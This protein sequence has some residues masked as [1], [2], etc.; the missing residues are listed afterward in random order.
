MSAKV[1]GGL[2]AIL[3]VSTN[4]SSP[5]YT[6]IAQVVEIGG[7]DWGVG[8]ADT[9]NLATPITGT[10]LRPTIAKPGTIT[11][12]LQYDPNDST[13]Q[14]LTG[15]MAA[16]AMAVWKITLTDVTPMHFSAQG[17]LT[18]F[19]LTGLAVESNVEADIE[20]A[21]SGPITIS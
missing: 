5:S 8:T 3:A 15:L 1:S 6:T 17:V 20:I 21:L 4:V 14:I 12:K 2:G 10:T 13:Q 9:T 18:K 7:P 16:P 19:A 11:A